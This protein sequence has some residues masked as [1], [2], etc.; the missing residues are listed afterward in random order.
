[1]PVN[2]ERPSQKRLVTPRKARQYDDALAYV[3]AEKE[4]GIE[5]LADQ[6]RREV[7]LPAC[8]RFGLTYRAG[9]GTYGFGDPNPKIKYGHPRYAIGNE[10][11]ARAAKLSALVDV[12]RVLGMRVDSESHAEIGHYIDDVTVA[13]MEHARKGAKT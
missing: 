9:N 10:H 3:L 5:R 6:I 8:V 2:A 13:Q 11:D 4:R 7:V 12:F 1:M